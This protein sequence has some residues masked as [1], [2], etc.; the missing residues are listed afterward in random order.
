MVLAT[1]KKGKP[2][3]RKKGMCETIRARHPWNHDGASLNST[4]G[5]V[6]VVNKM[7]MPTALQFCVIVVGFLHANISYFTITMIRIVI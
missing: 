1:V 7:H 6:Y 2:E 5:P 4:F 3:L